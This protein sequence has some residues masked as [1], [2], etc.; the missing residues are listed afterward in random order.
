M[1]VL[2]MA[3]LSF[4]IVRDASRV[5]AFTRWRMNLQGF[6]EVTLFREAVS[7]DIFRERVDELSFR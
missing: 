3:L 2:T 5:Y 4:I 6:L 7:S 1:E